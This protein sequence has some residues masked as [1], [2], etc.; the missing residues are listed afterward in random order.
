MS[1]DVSLTVKEAVP[2]KASSGIFIRENG[3]TK[4]ISA[5]EWNERYPDREPCKIIQEAD[6][7]TNKV[8]SDNITH[9]LGTMSEAAGIYMHLWR[10]DEIGIT[11]AR[12]LVIPLTEG[13]LKL[14]SDPEFYKTFNPKN[15]WGTYEG[16]VKFVEGYLHACAEFMDADVE[17]DR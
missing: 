6:A 13:L 10:P 11:K 1:L 3:G 12:Q 16:L 8:Y 14:T 9:N 17:V 2:I 5:E 4:E 7:T 15:G